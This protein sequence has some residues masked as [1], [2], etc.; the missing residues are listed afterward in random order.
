MIEA[1]QVGREGSRRVV[2]ALDASA[3]GQVAWEALGAGRG[4]SPYMGVGRGGAVG[5]V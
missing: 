3:G 4:A 5:A 2:G 1:V